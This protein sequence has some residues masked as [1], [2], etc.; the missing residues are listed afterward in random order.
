MMHHPASM[1]DSSLLLKVAEA[2]WD[3]GVVTDKK[4]AES[5]KWIAKMARD[6]FDTRGTLAM[7]GEDR[8]AERRERLLRSS[9]CIY[10]F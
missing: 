8:C 4:D 10:R 1:L 7:F 3:L 6:M 5:K 9:D 2:L